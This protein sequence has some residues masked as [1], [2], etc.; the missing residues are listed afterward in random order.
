MAKNGMG[1]KGGWSGGEMKESE[2]LN[3]WW[4]MNEAEGEI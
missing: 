4:E 3:L 1:G 2:Q